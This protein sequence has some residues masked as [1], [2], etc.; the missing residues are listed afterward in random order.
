[1]IK[2]GDLRN[3]RILLQFTEGFNEVMDTS[4]VTKYLNSIEFNLITSGNIDSTIDRVLLLEKFTFS[5]VDVERNKA[6][7][8][9]C[10]Q[11]MTD[12]DIKL[13]TKAI[14]GSTLME[15]FN[16]SFLIRV[17]FISKRTHNVYIHSCFNQIDIQSCETMDQMRI[18]IASNLS[19]QDHFNIG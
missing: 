11:N 8:F 10:I 2:L 17:M 13:M 1:M 7:F 16:S 5:G 6:L 15:Y 4:V 3:L 19:D 14:T 12:Q 18:L 9:S